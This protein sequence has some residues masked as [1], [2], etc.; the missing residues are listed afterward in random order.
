MSI[1]F[2]Q[3]AVVLAT[4]TVTTIIIFLVLAPPVRQDQSY[5]AFADRRTIVGVSNFWDTLSNVPFAVIGLVGLLAFRDLASR[6]IFLGIFAT[7]FGSA[8]YH[9]RPDDARL[10]WDR[11]PMTIVF[12]SLFALAIKQR[13][14]LIPLVLVGVASIVWWRITGNLW[15]YVLVQ[16]GSMIV[17]FV[18]AFRAEPGLRP[19]V[20]FYGLSKITE[21]FDTQIYSVLPLSGHTLKHVLAGVATWYIYRWIKLS[22]TG[23]Q[24]VLADAASGS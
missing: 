2:R 1:Q 24:P 23:L 11:L 4:L 21:F 16:F 15:P 13:A 18:I 5:H 12:M 7:A 8:Y 20:V 9:L 10:F 14:L 22:Q 3:R 17:L 19:V 6:I